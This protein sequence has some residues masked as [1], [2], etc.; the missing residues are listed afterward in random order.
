LP[1][2]K[3]KFPD[4]ASY[5]TA[6]IFEIL[7][8]RQIQNSKQFEAHTFAST[9]FANTGNGTFEA[10]PLPP[11]AQ[12]APVFDL[13]VDHFYGNETPDILAAGNNFGMRPEFG[14]MAGQG[15]LLKG[16]DD[17]GFIP[18]KSR[19][20]GF[21]AVGEVR[22]IELV[23][24]QTGPIILLGRYNDSI[25]PYLYRFPDPVTDNL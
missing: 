7:S 16:S 15:I 25:V 14:P 1:H 18:E 20:T 12:I 24:T 17:L 6:S 19:D 11:E 21:Y 13:M 3:D 8:S 23:P 9:V 10:L 22:K 4:Y 2:L 5:S